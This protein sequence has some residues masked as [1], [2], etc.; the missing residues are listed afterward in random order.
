METIR[1]FSER[2]DAHNAKNFDYLNHFRR[3]KTLP[4]KSRKNS[5]NEDTLVDY[6]DQVEKFK[7]DQYE[8]NWQ[9]IITQH[10][11]YAQI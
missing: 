10:L 5:V 1:K 3:S 7:A 9:D 6:N 8:K 4:Q 11:D 2:L